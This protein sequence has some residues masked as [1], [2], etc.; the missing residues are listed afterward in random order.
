MYIAY[1][2][3]QCPNCTRFIKII[4]R[5]RMENVSFVNID[6]Q[7]PRHPIRSV[8]SIVTDQGDVK[9]GTEAFTWLQQFEETL[10]LE[11]YATVL[12]AGDGGL[13]YTDLESDETIDTTPFTSFH[14]CT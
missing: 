2:S 4:Q 3:Q 14:P 6:A 12:G 13:T 8:P 5:L 10:P 9:E 11:A 1:V 7:A